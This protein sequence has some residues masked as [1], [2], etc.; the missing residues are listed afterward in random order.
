[1]FIIMP[2]PLPKTGLRNPRIRSKVEIGTSA[3]C[4]AC[5]KRIICPK[6]AF[7]CLLCNA[8]WCEACK[9]NATSTSQ[10]AERSAPVA[11]PI[12]KESAAPTPS[13]DS[14]AQNAEVAPPIAKNVRAFGFPLAKKSVP[15]APPIA[16][17]TA[18]PP[19]SIDGAGQ[20]AELAH[21]IAKKPTAGAPQAAPPPAT[22]S[23]PPPTSPTTSSNVDTAPAKA[24]GYRRGINVACGINF[25]ELMKPQHKRGRF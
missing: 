14:T 3:I 2:K 16:K 13:L 6:V 10:A 21:P 9:D 15:V 25:N 22:K 7:M 20:S 11:P 18:A 8:D 4:D 12:G 17:E 19:S 24:S 5:G 23:A 1:M